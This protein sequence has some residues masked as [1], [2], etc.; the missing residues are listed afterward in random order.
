MISVCEKSTAREFGLVSQKDAQFLQ[1]QLESDAA[2]GTTFFIDIATVAMLRDSG[3]STELLDVLA[4]SIDGRGEMEIVL[5]NA[6]LPVDSPPTEHSDALTVPG[7]PPTLPDRNFAD[8]TI[9]TIRG[10]DLECVVCG[11]TQFR[12]RNAQLHTALASF[13]DLEWLGPTAD[14]YVCRDCGYVHWFLT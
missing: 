12:H 10:R 13:F 11:N 7:A 2:E 8:A 3:A 5:V 6:S 4:T 1:S 9:V 14:C